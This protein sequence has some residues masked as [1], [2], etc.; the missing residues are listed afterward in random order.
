MF[1]Y[2]RDARDDVDD[3]VGRV[4]LSVSSTG[5]SGVRPAT[6]MSSALHEPPATESLSAP[7][8]PIL[9]LW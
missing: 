3:S 4:N 1:H 6:N 9:D 2:Q 5:Y 7:D 8:E